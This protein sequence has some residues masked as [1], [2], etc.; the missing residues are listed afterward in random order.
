[1][2]LDVVKADGSVEDY[3]HT[4]VLGTISNAFS[5]VGLADM[6]VAEELSEVVTYFVYKRDGEGTVSSNEIFSMIKVVLDSTGYGD[7]AI[8]LAEHH[9]QR[10]LKRSRT[11]VVSIDVN[12]LTDAQLCIF[13]EQPLKSRWDKSRIVE[14]L[15]GREGLDSRTARTIAS[16]VEEKV[17]GMGVNLVSSSL[18]KQLVLAET[19]AVI[20]AQQQLA[21]V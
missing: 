3:L 19:A 12:G 6:A 16:M 2:R 20:R 4:K 13:A 17:L 7:A 5:L 9:H 8:A 14:G 18:V 15:V 21:M 11:E 1:M 10:R